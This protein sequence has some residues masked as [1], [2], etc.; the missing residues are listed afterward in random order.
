MLTVHEQNCV[1]LFTVYFVQ[2]FE[3]VIVDYIAL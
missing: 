3:H 2:S 1:C